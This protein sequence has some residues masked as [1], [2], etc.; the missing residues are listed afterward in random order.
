[1]FAPLTVFLDL[2]TTGL[3]PRDDGITEIGAVILEEGRPVR[4]WSTLVRPAKPIPPEIARMTGI[5][6]EM[7]R[8]APT[9]ADVRESDVEVIV[10]FPES[11]GEGGPASSKISLAE[12]DAWLSTQTPTGRTAAEIDAE[13]AIERAS[14]D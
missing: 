11:A 13:L 2:E 6:N 14:W 8:D 4:E 10:L 9:F 1:M 3:S 5:T 12:F 7:V